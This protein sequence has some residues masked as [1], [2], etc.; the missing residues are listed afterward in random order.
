MDTGE[1]ESLNERHHACTVHY[2]GLSRMCSTKRHQD[3]GRG[4][5]GA[6]DERLGTGTVAKRKTFTLRPIINANVNEFI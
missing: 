3:A 5:W 6:K 4:C 1:G 2:K